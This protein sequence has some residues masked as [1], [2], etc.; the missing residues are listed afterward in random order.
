MAALLCMRALGFEDEKENFTYSEAGALLL[1][2]T[3]GL[4][5]D[6]IAE[7]TVD[8]GAAF[9]LFENTI[10]AEQFIY[11]AQAGSL[12]ATWARQGNGKTF[13]KDSF[14]INEGT[15]TILSDASWFAIDGTDG[16][17]EGNLNNVILE[18]IVNWTGSTPNYLSRVL[19]GAAAA[20][21]GIDMFDVGRNVTIFY[22][23][24]ANQGPTAHRIMDVVGGMRYNDEEADW[25]TGVAW[26]GG[27]GLNAA[28]RS[29]AG[30]AR[31]FTNA[32]RL[33]VNYTEYTHF[34]NA[35]GVSVAGQ[36]MFDYPDLFPAGEDWMW[37][38]I[39]S[40]FRNLGNIQGTALTDTNI[41]IVYDSIN[42]RAVYLEIYTYSRYDKIDDNKIKLRDG[43][44]A[45]LLDV[46]PN[47]VRGIRSLASGDRFLS[48]GI[49]GKYGVKL[50]DDEIVEGKATGFHNSA[51]TV[52]GKN[53]RMSDLAGKNPTD[54]PFDRFMIG[55]TVYTL[56]LYRGNIVEIGVPEVPDPT[57]FA[58]ITQ[59][60][61]ATVADS[62][63][64]YFE[65]EVRLLLPD[66][67]TLQ[68]FILADTDWDY[69]GAFNSDPTGFVEVG[70]LIHWDD[71]D[72]DRIAIRS[73]NNGSTDGWDGNTAF[74]EAGNTTQTI[75]RSNATGMT[76]AERTWLDYEIG[77]NPALGVVSRDTPIYVE[78]GGRWMVFSGAT[79]PGFNATVDV[80]AFVKEIDNNTNSVDVM[81]I[82]FSGIGTLTNVETNWAVSTGNLGALG[83]RQGLEVFVKGAGQPVWMY[84]ATGGQNWDAA[85]A[86]GTIFT[87]AENSEGF[88]VGLTDV[89]DYDLGDLTAVDPG[90]SAF[91]HSDDEDD[92]DMII[93]NANNTLTIIGGGG[94]RGGATI[95]QLGA[96][97]ND[98]GETFEINRH[99]DG[100]NWHYTFICMKKISFREIGAALNE[101]N[102]PDADAVS[103]ANVN[104]VISGW[105]LGNGDGF[106]RNNSLSGWQPPNATTFQDAGTWAVYRIVLEAEE[107][108]LFSSESLKEFNAEWE[109][110]D[111]GGA[112]WQQVFE[113]GDVF[114]DVD[115]E[116]VRFVNGRNG[117][118]TQYTLEIRFRIQAAGGPE[119]V[120]DAFDITELGAGL[121]TIISEDKAPWAANDI[122]VDEGEGQV[123]VFTSATAFVTYDLDLSLDQDEEY[124]NASTAFIFSLVEDDTFRI[125]FSNLI[126]TVNFDSGGEFLEIND[127]I[128]ASTVTVNASAETSIGIGSGGMTVRLNGNTEWVVGCS[129]AT[130]IQIDSA[131]AKL[132]LEN[133]WDAKFTVNI[134]A[135]TVVEFDI[136]DAATG[137]GG[138]FTTPIAINFTAAGAITTLN[139]DYDVTITGAVGTVGTIKVN[140]DDL[141]IRTSRATTVDV[142]DLDENEN[143]TVITTAAVQIE[144]TL[145][146]ATTHYVVDDYA[147]TVGSTWTLDG[148]TVGDKAFELTITGANATASNPAAD[149][150]HAQSWIR[151]TGA[152]GT[153]LTLERVDDID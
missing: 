150:N 86:A 62:W 78:V 145:G 107:G 52:D 120:E 152:N 30:S 61:D 53:Y 117:D 29:A 144:F 35:Y 34:G 39:G 130:T 49:G 20:K 142:T 33:F 56:Y 69:D 14:G 90:R 139:T 114:G 133:W 25:D 116:E 57:N 4:L 92:S 115:L 46:H 19:D 113:S 110:N 149:G 17:V 136:D 123:I 68:R 148:D 6:V 89:S 138:A 74:I 118:M 59:V 134:G 41:R 73:V 3:Y 16:T 128:F 129:E 50:Y 42:V 67:S 83:G 36:V 23:I 106:T 104:T 75:D 47:N 60:R 126:N 109:N 143:V 101:D 44:D 76:R 13:L 131:I 112:V 66:G 15:F 98:E 108:A 51:V 94:Q 88:V 140:D 7:G 65:Q 72:D 31:S 2:W 21:L 96:R 48:F 58:L 146:A 26:D 125:N 91:W 77:E 119:P 37:Q 22:R 93:V 147:L 124:A 79:L 132:T 85:A 40:N 135:F 121:Y 43:Y 137:W 122:F 80:Q 81:A 100:G 70:D 111:Q 28:V 1:A 97:F 55:D 63:T 27:G 84:R 71:V 5:D 99:M 95:A 12:V 45:T 11:I 10:R 82:A 64:G 103:G 127:S 102:L 18:Y 38:G 87:Y 8:R 141:T 24:P 153:I 54:F 9:L 105:L 151:V 32:T